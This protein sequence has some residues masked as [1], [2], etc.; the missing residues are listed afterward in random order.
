MRIGRVAHLQCG[1]RVAQSQRVRAGLP[2]THGEGG[3]GHDDGAD[4][5]HHGRGSRQEHLAAALDP[6]PQVPD[7]EYDLS[8]RDF[9]VLSIYAT[10]DPGNPP[11][12]VEAYKKYLPA[13][14]QYVEIEGGNHC[15][16]GYYID[17]R[18]PATITREKQHQLVVSATA[19]F[20]NSSI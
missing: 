13:D 17:E 4:R 1:E 14:T 2:V 20:I 11:S 19:D 7:A 18:N 8:K 10:N 3:V 9:A 5:R 16:F 12:Q 6:V 15:Q